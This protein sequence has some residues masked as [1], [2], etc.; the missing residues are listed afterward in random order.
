MGDSIAAGVW[1]LADAGGWLI[2]PGDLPLVTP[3]SLERVA[4]ALL[5]DGVVVPYWHERRGH[6]VGFGADCF[7][8][9]ACLSGDA[10]AAHVVRAL[11]EC[12]AMR[13]LQLDDDQGIVMDVDTVDDLAH[14]H[15]LL[16][17]RRGCGT[18]P[19][20]KVYGER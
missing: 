5:P 13:P 19:Q 16:C 11:S 4:R 7:G 14:A 9:L 8:A 6:P 17:Q 3:A 12:G 2:L 18:E 10:G 15:A 1:A 20:E